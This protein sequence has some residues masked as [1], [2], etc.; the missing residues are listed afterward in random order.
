MSLDRLIRLLNDLNTSVT[1]TQGLVDLT[2]TVY[3]WQ[4]RITIDELASIPLN[5][6]WR[7][8]LLHHGDQHLYKLIR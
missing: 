4:Y 5:I 7:Q 3:E 6:N 1:A 2:S 8:S